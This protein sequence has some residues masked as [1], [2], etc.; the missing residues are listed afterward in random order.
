MAHVCLIAAIAFAVADWVAVARRWQLL[1][2]VA[3]P[4]ALGCLLLYAALGAHTSWYLIA[5]LALSL[6]GDVYLMLPDRLF[7]AGLA[8]F[9]LAHLAYVADFDATMLARATW[10]VLVVIAS[11][12]LAMRIIRGVPNMPLRAGVAVY[13]AVISL[14]VASAIASG[15]LVAAAGALLFFLSDSLI[16]VNRFVLPFASAPLA[17]IVSYHAAQLLLVTAL[18]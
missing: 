6:L 7:P 11:V 10:F 5:A 2:Y 12:P 1:E 13:M 9:L 3:K 16:A 8:A 18:R 15:H 14:M 17:I 4:A